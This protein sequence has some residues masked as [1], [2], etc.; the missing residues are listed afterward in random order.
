MAE[1]F[2]NRII[3]SSAA[4]GS[5]AI[6][7]ATLFK[8]LNRK[9]GLIRARRARSSASR[10]CFTSSASQRALSIVSFSRS[11]ALQK[12][13][14]GETDHTQEFDLCIERVKRPGPGEIARQTAVG[15]S[16]KSLSVSSGD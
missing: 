3:I 13:S 12:A 1:D 5:A 16:L 9:C 10:S 7:A 2:A 4:R 6:N 15:S 8:E 14:H 11:I